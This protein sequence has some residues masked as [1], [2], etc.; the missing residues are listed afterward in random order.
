LKRAGVET[1]VETT[2]IEPDSIW[3]LYPDLMMTSTPNQTDPL[4]T[5]RDTITFVVGSPDGPRST[6]WKVVLS[7]KG[8]IYLAPRELMH[9]FKISLHP[10]GNWVVAEDYE[11]M[12]ARGGGVPRPNSERIIRRWTPPRDRVRGVQPANIIMSFLT[13]ELREREIEAGSDEID[14]IPAAPTGCRRDVMLYLH[15]G[16]DR[17]PSD[18]DQFGDR[19]AVHMF[20]PIGAVLSNG[21][22]VVAVSYTETYCMDSE[23]PWAEAV[24]ANREVEP[25]DVYYFLPDGV[26]FPWFYE[27]AIDE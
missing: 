12:V 5:K 16:E 24:K 8:D 2:R 15:H 1:F 3:H 7:A 19:I 17:G 18:I 13:S 26:E 21:K 4:S 22:L 25:G 6:P 27:F 10:D 20:P 11:Y 23:Q 9:S 14:W